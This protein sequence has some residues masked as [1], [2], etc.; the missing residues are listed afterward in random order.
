MK[1]AIDTYLEFSANKLTTFQR[2]RLQILRY[3][4]V[5]FKTILKTF[6]QLIENRL[7]IRA[8]PMSPLTAPRLL[9]V[10]AK[11]L[12]VAGVKVDFEELSFI[13]S[14]VSAFHTN[15]QEIA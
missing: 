13:V 4:P 10:V 12:S 5:T 6:F 9:I 2:I 11:D 3:F 1:K 8:S 7:N 15:R 14:I